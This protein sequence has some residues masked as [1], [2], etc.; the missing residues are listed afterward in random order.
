MEQRDGTTHRRKGKHLNR[1]ERIQIEVLL[2]KKSS[3][4]EIADLLSRHRRTIE[5]EIERGLV[6]HMNTELIYSK[7]YSSDRGQ[8]VHIFNAT[9]KGPQLKLGSDYEA[10]EFIRMQIVENKASPAVV[11]HR[12]KEQA[13]S[14]T[15]CTKTIYSYIE[16]GLIVG[17]TNETLWE[18]RQRNKRARRT[19]RRTAKKAAMPGHGIDDRPKEVAS[20]SEFGHWEIDL[21]VSATGTS[22]YAMMTLVERK[23]RKLLIRRI[24]NKTQASVAKALNGIERAMGREAFR[25]TFKSIT[26]DNGS[27][28]LDTSLLEQSVLGTQKRTFFYYAH[29]YASWE[30]GTNENANRMIRRFIARG[31]DISKFTCSAIKSIEQW[32]NS[33]PRKILDFKTAEELFT[34]ELAA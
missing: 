25:M 27:E 19:L 12:M 22:N 5:R 20:R 29:P 1:D 4:R 3:I 31:S 32:I 14:C 24:K 30:R 15:V 7:V 26:A 11:A 21:V 13:M 23:T 34:L 2:K 6:D 10:A 17:V 28:F 18:K 16:E 8:A 33:Y 9:A